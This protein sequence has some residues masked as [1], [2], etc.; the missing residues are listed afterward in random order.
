[1][2]I[3]ETVKQLGTLITDTWERAQN[4]MAT[5]DVALIS[6]IMKASTQ[7]SIIGTVISIAGALLILLA[8]THY[9]YRPSWAFWFLM[10]FLVLGLLN[11]P[12]LF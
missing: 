12:L 3:S 4:G 7:G 8:Y 10:A 6:K 2:G 9:R 1:M 5:V 11:L